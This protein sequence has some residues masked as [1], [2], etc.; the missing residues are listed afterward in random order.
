MPLFEYEARTKDGEVQVGR[1]EALNREAAAEILQRH[2]LIIVTLESVEEKPIFQKRIAFFEHVDRKE[3]SVFSRQLSTLFKASVPLVVSIRTLANQTDNPKFKDI[4]L[5]VA[6]NI[7]G[8]MPF[9]QALEEYPETFSNFYVQMIRAGEESGNLD[10]VLSYLAEY[11]ERDYYIA[12]KIKGAMTYP[13][14]IIGVFILVGMAVMLF[15]IPN[16]LQVLEQSGATDL[17]FLTR[18]IAFAS[19]LTQDAWHIML[20]GM[21]AFVVG[22]WRF[23]KTDT[24]HDIWSR[25][26]LKLPIFG[27]LFKNIYMFR[28]SSSLSMLVRGGVPVNRSLD[29]TA[30]VIS[31]IVYQ[32]IF[33]ELRDKVN[34][35][36]SI[37][38]TLEKY[39]QVDV[40]VTQMIAVGERTGKLSDILGN[41]SQF[42]E[43]EINN[44]IDNLVS[45]IEPIMIVAIGIA[46]ALLVAG[47]L[48]PMYN[49]ISAIG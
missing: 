41:V 32:G 15:V 1:V 20:I 28:F 7:D 48:L 47:V 44:T 49:T 8:G 43:D 3:I 12:S 36:D 22:I 37:S 13:A 2:S 42:Y 31:N 21:V 6:S 17:P 29:I 45:L 9:S 34:K 38:K 25:V 11:T 19:Q 14:F 27:K 23:I 4:L 10:E 39:E 26:Q 30:N 18:A 24:G 40:M 5:S 46:V 33:E 16:L 35:G